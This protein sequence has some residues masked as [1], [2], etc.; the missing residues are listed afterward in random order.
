MNNKFIKRVV[1]P[2]GIVIAAVVLM[3][4]GPLPELS[5]G[6][7]AGPPPN[8]APVEWQ[9][10]AVTGS[11]GRVEWNNSYPYAY[12]GDSQLPKSTWN[13]NNCV[14]DILQFKNWSGTV[15][16]VRSIVPYCGSGQTPNVGYPMTVA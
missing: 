2:V 11:G 8:K 5:C 16:Q 10:R 3:G 9:R 13:I 1:K 14:N 15:D 4:F 12:W 7:P 6:G